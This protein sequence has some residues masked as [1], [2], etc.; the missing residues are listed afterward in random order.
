MS[1]LY[2]TPGKLEWHLRI[3]A[4]RGNHLVI[5]FTGGSFSSRGI[6]CGSYR[7]DNPVVRKLIEDSDEFRSGLIRVRN[8]N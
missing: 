7:T 1:R 2:Y 3:P 4:A 6:V 8:E 5:S